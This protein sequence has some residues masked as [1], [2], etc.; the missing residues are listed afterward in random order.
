[1]KAYK[2]KE[3]RVRLFRPM[4]NIE[5]MQKSAER[6]ALPN[7]DKDEML[8][9]IKE[10]V[11][12]ESNWIPSERGYSLYL[13]PTM[14]GTQA[15][16]GVGS[17][18]NAKVFLIASPVGPYYRTGFSAVKL[19]ADPTAVRAWPG[20]SGDSKLGGNYAPGIRT[21][22][23]AAAKGYAQVLWLFGPEHYVTEVGTMNC[24]MLWK[25]E[26]G[27]SRRAP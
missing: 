2:D 19:F 21:Q 7:F 4:M 12:V 23:D 25:N 6:I 26:D 15:S 20:G 11:K 14:I 27:G 3:G 5:R 1:M 22:L 10:F 9:C 18:S 16:L 13:R 17:S 8:K 24:F